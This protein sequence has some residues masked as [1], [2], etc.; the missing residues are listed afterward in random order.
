MLYIYN[1]CFFLLVWSTYLIYLFDLL[2]WSTC[3]IYLFDLLVW[4][5][6]GKYC[7]RTSELVKVWTK[8]SYFIK[9]I[10]IMQLP[11]EF[12]LFIEGKSGFLL[13]GRGGGVTLP[14]PLVV[15]PLKKLFFMCVFP[16]LIYLFDLLIWSTYLIY[17]F[18]LLVWCRRTNISQQK[19]SQLAST[20]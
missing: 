7:F 4:S 18:N 8:T 16:Y 14:T 19:T 11:G 20:R 13:S 2:I 1:D 12:S 17:L 6:F 10:F 15:R 3:L 9:N 5:T